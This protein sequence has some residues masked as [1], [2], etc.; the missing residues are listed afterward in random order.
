MPLF[1][2]SQSLKDQG[3]SRTDHPRTIHVP[4]GGVAIP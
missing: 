3:K 4:I 1:Y 2:G